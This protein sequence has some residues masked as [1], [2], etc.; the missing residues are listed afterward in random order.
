MRVGSDVSFS[1]IYKILRLQCG[2]DRRVPTVFQVTWLAERGGHNFGFFI[3]F[4]VIVLLSSGCFTC[5]LF[6]M[7]SESLLV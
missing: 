5:P 1:E 6:H 7:S 2:E 3:E 4:G